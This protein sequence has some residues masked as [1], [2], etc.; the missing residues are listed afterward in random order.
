MFGFCKNFKKL[1]KNLGFHLTLK[2]NDL[3]IIITNSLAK[4]INVTVN[5]FYL[6]VPVLILD[7]NTQ[8][9]FNESNKNNYIITYDSWHTERK[10]STDG[11]EL[12]FDIA[13]ARHINSPK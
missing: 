9:M 3:Q 1:T 8:V 2:T 4:D 6:Y 5:N 11:N 10:L 13:R 12:Q 7:S